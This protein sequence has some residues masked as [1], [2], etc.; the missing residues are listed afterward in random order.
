MVKICEVTAYGKNDYQ[1]V[2]KMNRMIN[3]EAITREYLINIENVRV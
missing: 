2:I 3:G 1:K